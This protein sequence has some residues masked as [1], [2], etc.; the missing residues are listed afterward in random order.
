MIQHGPGGPPGFWVAG[1]PV[2]S[3]RGF[4][5]ASWKLDRCRRAVERLSEAALRWDVLSGE[6]IAQLRPAIGFDGWCAALV[7][8]AT[9]LPATAIAEDSPVACCQR[10]F[11]QL[12]YQDPDFSTA[13]AADAGGR[14]VAVLS[15]VTRGDLA[16]SRRWDELLRPAG[17]ADELRAALEADGARWGSLTLYRAVRGRWFSDDE[18]RLMISLHSALSRAARAGWAAWPPAPADCEQEPATLLATAAGTITDATPAAGTWLA[19]L[20]PR[21]QSGYSLVYALLA[22]L[23]A[24]INRNP[25]GASSASLVTRTADGHWAELHAA[26]LTGTGRAGPHVAVTVQPALPARIRAVLTRA[27]ALSDREGQVARLVLDGRPVADIAAALYISPHTVRDH[28]KAIYRKTRS[29][30]RHE[31]AARLSGYGP[32][33]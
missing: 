27:H 6:L 10:R 8:P 1:G 25:G 24:D 2:Q 33:S 3:Y 31:L 19:R 32:A 14:K 22:R 30:T 29:H 17:T 21:P 28:L 18:M 4:M 16:R 26:P 11:Y 7:D 20:G 9:G 5:R 12:E 13:E 23:T 15:D